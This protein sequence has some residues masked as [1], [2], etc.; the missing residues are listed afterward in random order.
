MLETLTHE[1]VTYRTRD[2]RPGED[3]LSIWD[4]ILAAEEKSW[5][6]EKNDAAEAECRS[7]FYREADAL[8]DAVLFPAEQGY[9]RYKG[10]RTA[11]EQIMKSVPTGHGSSR[12]RVLPMRKTPT[13]L[14]FSTPSLKIQATSHLHPGT[15]SIVA[16][17]KPHNR[18]LQPLLLP[19]HRKESR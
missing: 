5:D 18:I 17:L 6:D 12:M 8:E 13:F 19:I 2:I 11:I 16:A 3:V 7:D 14:I 9:A 4:D 10:N 1:P 15:E